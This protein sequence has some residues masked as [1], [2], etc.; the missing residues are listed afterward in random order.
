LGIG[1]QCQLKFNYTEQ[2]DGMAVIKMHTSYVLTS[3]KSSSNLV[4]QKSKKRSQLILMYY[5]H[6]QSCAARDTSTHTG[7]NITY[8]YSSMSS[9]PL[10]Q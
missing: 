2:N 3:V 5:T 10:Q 8:I 7:A 4:K 6:M 9:F 1:R